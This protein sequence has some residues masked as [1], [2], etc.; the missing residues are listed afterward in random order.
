MNTQSNAIPE[1]TLRSRVNT[2]A[3]I[4]ASQLMYWSVQRE[5]WENR[6][7]Y[8]APLAVA[9]LFLF[10]FTISMIHLPGKMGAALALGPLHQHE[11]IAQPYDFAALLIMATTFIVGIFY[12]LEALHGERRDRR[13]LFWKSLPVS[14]L[15]TVLSKASIPLVVLPLLTFAITVATQAIM[16]LL[17]TAVLL[18]SGLSVETLWTQVPL[19]T[20]WLG[21][22]YHLV[23][24][25]ALYYAPIFGWLLLVSSWA[26]RAAFL[27]AGLP[28]L[29]IAFV[30]K[31][32]FNTSH[33][34]A[35]LESRISGGPEA[36]A[37]P[38]PAGVPMDSM[39]HL[40][41]LGFLASPGLWI[42][43]A[44]AAA[45][46]AAAVRLRRYQGPI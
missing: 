31:I 15:T 10:G 25:H 21:L 13:I 39:T 30:E 7:I 2:P 18:G 9:A 29:A 5:L 6:S 46:L 27:W 41:L 22:F 17:G 32:A 35:M 28:L 4:S 36:A 11:V 16:L 33:V 38:M 12:C 34:F 1:S 42:G 19:F 3:I 43:L 8:I 44:M 14:D 20:M 26:R 37:F 24:V 23:T 45:F 40:A